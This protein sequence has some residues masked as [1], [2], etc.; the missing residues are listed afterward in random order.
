MSSIEARI[1][2]SDDEARFAAL[3]LLIAV[4]L[5][6]AVI[7][8]PLC[9]ATQQNYVT[10]YSGKDA[11]VSMNG[12]EIIE[13]AHLDAARFDGFFEDFESARSIF[14]DEWS[15]SNGWWSSGNCPKEDCLQ[16]NVTDNGRLELKNVKHC[17][18]GE[19]YIF[20]MFR[21]LAPPPSDFEIHLPLAA[22]CS[23]GS[24]NGAPVWISIILYDTQY[25]RQLEA[26]FLYSSTFTE[27]RTSLYGYSNITQLGANSLA[28]KIWRHSSTMSFSIDN[29]TSV[30]AQGEVFSDPAVIELRFNI[31]ESDTQNCETQ[32]DYLISIDY[33][34]MQAEKGFAVF[35]DLVAGN[36]LLLDG[37]KVNQRFSPLH[38]GAIFAGSSDLNSDLAGLCDVPHSTYGNF[39]TS[40]QLDYFAGNGSFE[41][42][43]RESHDDIL[44]DTCNSI[45]GWSA[46]DY[47]SGGVTYSGP[48]TNGYCVYDYVWSS[49]SS[50]KILNPWLKKE[51]DICPSD[52]SIELKVKYLKAIGNISAV[53]FNELTLC[54]TNGSVV[55]NSTP[56]NLS[57][58]SIAT[59]S[60]SFK[61][62]QPTPL[63]SI[64][65][66]FVANA[67][68]YGAAYFSI[69]NVNVSWHGDSGLTIMGVPQLDLVR[70]CP[71]NQACSETISNGS[72]IVIS[73][74]LIMQPFAGKIEVVDRGYLRPHLNYTSPVDWNDRIEYY[75]GQF[76]SSKSSAQL[77]SSYSG[78]ECD[79][80]AGWEFRHALL[81]G[82]S[83]PTFSAYLGSLVMQESFINCAGNPPYLEAYYWFDFPI[84]ITGKE[85]LLS[86]SADANFTFSASKTIL[87]KYSEISVYYLSNGTL[88]LVN[89][90][91]KSLSPSL[92]GSFLISPG[93]MI[94]VDKIVVEVH[95]YARAV[96]GSTLIS[97]NDQARVHYLRLNY[98]S[99]PPGY[100]GLRVSGLQA[101]WNLHLGGLSYWP[102]ANGTIIIP[103]NCTSWPEE[104]GFT[105]FRPTFYF[106]G[107][108][109]EGTRYS[110][111]FEKTFV[112]GIR[113][114]FFEI[115]TF[116]FSYRVEMALSS[117]SF[118]PD[119]TGGIY[120]ICFNYTIVNDGRATQAAPAVAY[121]NDNKV[122]LSRMPDGLW[123]VSFSFIGQSRF[124]EME[125]FDQYGI[126]LKCKVCIRG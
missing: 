68:N 53:A 31:D 59:I 16:L 63:N 4:L 76:F 61:F 95:A 15:G 117:I 80:K 36:W 96:L 103:I 75:N 81:T 52:L 115:R 98:S 64:R 85:I 106:K 89:S 26:N 42:L 44:I 21:K 71:D 6:Y 114:A 23:N 110:L 109:A 3:R 102:D 8:S 70:V 17:A 38:G 124:V 91:A 65:M 30:V 104:N 126:C 120:T 14:A 121:I 10:Y 72:P 24:A 90:S 62:S 13:E 112:P 105:V 78:S 19:R 86:V 56:F 49:S 67:T 118:S 48:G 54:L 27:V 51:V 37:G 20:S 74:N 79:T 77:I 108:F 92:N 50:S 73:P 34:R 28:L 29:G 101:D 18:Y 43:V 2:K 87:S 57:D 1:R 119:R 11:I 22:S 88:F 69:Y 47:T 35:S 55:S 84:N 82:G 116:S 7:S 41:M 25:N 83:A 66:G 99:V 46:S 97:Q 123:G 40:T 111:S 94:Q 100:E 45:K 122:E 12:P 93:K 33:I 107:P 32:D 58:D 60:Y 113:G 9:L 39:S 5:S 125:V